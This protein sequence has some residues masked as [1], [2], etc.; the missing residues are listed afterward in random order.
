MRVLI[1]SKNMLSALN[2][3]TGIASIVS[4]LLNLDMLDLHDN[5]ISG[6]LDLAGLKMGNL[7][8]LRILNLCNNQL[9]S[10]E[11]NCSMKS[12]TEINLRNNKI[13]EIKA[14]G[15]TDLKFENLIKVYL[16]NN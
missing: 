2:G 14:E 4:C 8:N 3:P 13:K 5:R 16:S 9:D 15:A 10:I 6:C 7:Q 1:L 12:L 11:L